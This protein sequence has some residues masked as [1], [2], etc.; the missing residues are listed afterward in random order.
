ML[1]NRRDFSTLI[2]F[3]AQWDEDEDNRSK[4]NKNNY[5]RDRRRRFRNDDEEFL[6]DE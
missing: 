1:R 3:D 4:R 2:A 5:R 6:Y